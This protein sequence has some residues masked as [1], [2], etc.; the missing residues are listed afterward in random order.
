MTKVFIDHIEQ[1]ALDQD[2]YDTELVLNDSEYSAL[3]FRLHLYELL[4]RF[5]RHPYC[6]LI[7]VAHGWA[8]YECRDEVIRLEEGQS[9]LFNEGILHHLMDCSPGAIIEGCLYSSRLISGGSRVLYEKYYRPLHANEFYPFIVFNHGREWEKK[10][11]G[12]I[13]E[14]IGRFLRKE[15]DCELLARNDLTLINA[16]I[17][18]HLKEST[19][20]EKGMPVKQ[21]TRMVQMVIFI[22]QH[23]GETIRVKDIAESASISATEA[24]RIFRN[25]RNMSVS[26]YLLY[27][28]IVNAERLLLLGN[29]TVQNVAQKCGFSSAA[30]FT[31]VFRKETG[32]LPKDYRKSMQ[33]EN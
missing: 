5:H 30:Y 17:I 10:I 12:Q 16:S 20:A 9:V 27:V 6:Q 13:H 14:I 24:N 11:A 1:E 28:R 26:Q 19:P 15:T 31:R 2:Q 32:V 4:P 21:R 23:Y 22:E 33:E 3:F 29:D 8:E 7:S 18:H 25:H